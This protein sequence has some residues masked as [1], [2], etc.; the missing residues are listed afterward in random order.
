MILPRELI[1]Q[2][3]CLDEVRL[4]L[5]QYPIKTDGALATYKYDLSYHDDGD[6]WVTLT[7]PAWSQNDVVMDGVLNAI[8]RFRAAYGDKCKVYFE[9]NKVR[10]C[11]YFH[12]CDP[13]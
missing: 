2:D 8:T 6:I 7:F 13:D 1:Y 11:I 10:I 5:E 4:F 9:E 3:S 12:W